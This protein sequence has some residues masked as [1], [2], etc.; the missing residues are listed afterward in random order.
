MWS[1]CQAT[2]YFTRQMETFIFSPQD[3]LYFH[4]VLWPLLHPFFL[5]N[6]LFLKKP[7]PFQ[8]S[9]GDH[10]GHYSNPP[11]VTD[12]QLLNVNAII[13]FPGPLALGLAR[14]PYVGSVSK[15][16]F[17]SLRVLETISHLIPDD[18]ADYNTPQVQT[19]RNITTSL[20]SIVWL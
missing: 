20:G 14:H 7:P 2:S 18:S 6:S 9:N 16:H 11:P 13:A 4:H 1:L 8:Y 12:M 5:Q 19:F 10:Q 17:S 3:R 15:S